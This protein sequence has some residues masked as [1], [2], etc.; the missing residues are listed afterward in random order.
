MKKFFLTITLAF[1][2]VLVSAQVRV[3]AVLDSAKI[4][5]GEPTHWSVVVDAPKGAKVAYAHFADTTNVP[6]GIEVMEQ[7]I[8]TVRNGNAYT[9]AFRRTLT[10]WDARNYELPAVTVQVDGK[11]Y[12][13]DKLAF[14]V[15]EVK[16]DT[17]ATAPARPN[18]GIQKPPFQLTEWL[19]Y[20]GLCVLA[21]LLLAVAYAISLRLKNQKPLV[22]RRQPERK[23]LPHEKAMRAI[24]QV[25]TQ[26]SGTDN[27]DEKTYYTALTDILRE[28]LEDRFGIKAMEM[29]S[30]EIVETLRRESNSETN[31]ELERVFATADLVKFAKY[32]TQDN[33][34]NYYLGNVVDYIEET[35][36]GYQPP[37]EPTLSAA[38]QED[39]RNLRMRRILRWCKYA[40]IVAALALAVI[41]AWG[42]TELMN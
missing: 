40:A 22:K 9:L 24:E 6:R 15:E 7:H 34:K 35:K 37:Q 16:V 33:E 19:P 38:E 26:N 21:L 32:S 3:K 31:A 11:D 5:I 30:A 1:V 17:A 25:R 14:D 20:Y 8:D 12:T 41:A 36:A 13:T 2:A 27:A 29:T 23:L 18:D 39:L 4:L 28:Y 42:I 10:A